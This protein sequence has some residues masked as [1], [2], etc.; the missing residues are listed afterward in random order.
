MFSSHFFNSQTRVCIYMSIETE[1]VVIQFRQCKWRVRVFLQ[2]W[3]RCFTLNTGRWL[4]ANKLEWACYTNSWIF[5]NKVY[6]KVS[7]RTN[8]MYVHQ[9]CH[10]DLTTYHFY[11]FHD[12]RIF[13]Q[14]H[15]VYWQRVQI[16][17]DGQAFVNILMTGKCDI[18]VQTTLHQPCGP[19]TH[20]AL[21]TPCFVQTY[22]YMYILW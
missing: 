3:I 9:W 18:Q 5:I 15:L 14:H 12:V 6:C 20:N 1:K 2:C 13:L 17:H 7:I 8:N 4:T 10:T 22:K 19:Q 21:T 11:G 16:L